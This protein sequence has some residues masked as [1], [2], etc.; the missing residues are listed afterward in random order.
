VIRADNVTC[1]CTL[2][3]DSCFQY[4]F[5]SCRRRALT[6]APRFRVLYRLLFWRESERT[7]R[8]SAVDIL[9]ISPRSPLAQR[10]PHVHCARAPKFAR[11][12]RKRAGHARKNKPTE[13]EA[14]IAT[15]IPNGARGAIVWETG[16]SCSEF[17]RNRCEP[18]G[19]T[20]RSARR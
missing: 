12:L 20:D 17:T 6:E 9:S 18:A 11:V 5:A 8:D 10:P 14:G 1:N 4:V 7:R 3:T 13:R 19:I 16:R 2:S 15:A